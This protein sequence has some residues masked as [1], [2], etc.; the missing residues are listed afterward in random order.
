MSH[1]QTCFLLTKELFALLKTS[2]STEEREDKMVQVTE[3]LHEREDILPRLTKPATLQEEEMAG[4]IVAMN[5]FI[6]QQLTI[7]LG[8]IQRDRNG[9][10][11]KK[12]SAK[13]YTNP[14]ANMQYDGMFYDKRK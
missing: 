4:Q 8:D 13:R 3:L 7:L 9:L 11:K 14:Y 10:K 12:M 2:I 5:M 6:D 1:I